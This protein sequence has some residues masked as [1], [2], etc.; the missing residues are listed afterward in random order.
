VTCIGTESRGV[1]D[2]YDGYTTGKAPIVR[3]RAETFKPLSYA[4]VLDKIK[5]QRIIVDRFGCI[6]IFSGL[7]TRR[8]MRTDSLAHLY[9]PLSFRCNLN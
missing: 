7:L 6:G 8:R 4:S 5:A 1:R 2:A 9:L 3:A